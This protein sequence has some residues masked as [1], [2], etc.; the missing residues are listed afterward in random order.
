[1]KDIA[2]HYPSL[3]INNLAKAGPLIGVTW[4]T[5]RKRDWGGGR[6]EVSQTGVSGYFA[7]EDEISRTVDLRVS[8]TK[9]AFDF[10]RLWFN[11]DDCRR[12]AGVL[13]WK[14]ERWKCRRCHNLTYLSQYRT[15]DD[16]KADEYFR[17][18]AEVERGRPAYVRLKT[19]RTTLARLEALHADLN[20]RTLLPTRANLDQSRITA[21]YVRLRYAGVGQ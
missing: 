3:H 1:M 16:R 20:G 10:D 6:F 14:N 19:W 9:N 17:L 7:D 5:D 4:R 21:S 15:P 2:E 8:T 11:C 13:F 12:R 18:T